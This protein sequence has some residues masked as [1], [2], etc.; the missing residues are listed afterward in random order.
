MRLRFQA[1]VLLF[2]LLPAVAIASS[3]QSLKCSDKRDGFSV[4]EIQLEGTVEAG[5][6]I[7]LPVAEDADRLYAGGKLLGSTGYLLKYPFSARF[8]PRIYSLQPLQGQSNPVLTLETQNY[9]SPSGPPFAKARV[10]PASFPLRKAYLP[11]FLRTFAFFAL[12]ALS[13]FVVSRIRR[14]TVDGWMYPAEEM[15]WFFGSICCFLLLHSSYSHILVPGLWDALFHEAATKA[16]LAVGLWCLSTL[17]LN[18]RFNDR[19]CV[20]R[21][22]SRRPVFRFHFLADFALAA[23]L[24]TIVP[25][26]RASYPVVLA[27]HSL[28]LLLSLHSSVVSLEWRRVLKRSGASPLLF[29]FSL[30]AFGGLAALFPIFHIALGLTPAFLSSLAWAALL[31]GAFRMHSYLKARRRSRELV[32]E[33]REIL[34]HHSRADARLHALCEFIE[35]EWA[36]ARVSIISVESELGLVIASAGPEAIPDVHRS[37]ARKLGPFLRRV[38]RAGHILY[39]PVAEELGQDLQKEGLKHSSLAI[40]LRQLGKV[41]AVLCM[42]ADEGERIPPVEATVLELLAA[43][44]SLE[45]LS[46]SA[47]HVA[48][49]KCVH[50]LAIARQADGIAVEHLDDWGHLHYSDKEDSRYLVGAK[51]EAMLAIPGSSA[52]KKAQGE[53]SRE[54]RAIWHALALS[55]EFVP[56]EIKEDFWVLSPKEFRNPFLR[57]LGP[58]RVSLLLAMALDRQAR[59]LA[60]KEGFLLLAQPAF[61]VVAGSARLHLVSYGAQETGAYEVDALDLD[62]LRRLRDRAPAAGPACFSLP[63]SAAGFELRAVRAGREDE[64]YFSILSLFADKKELRKIENKALETAR[65]SLRKAA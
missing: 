54:L 47:Q 63:E 61:R 27:I 56:R 60:A 13:V 29:H 1:A 7:F 44:L 12:A 64:E 34:V 26:L 24:I 40:P 18:A 50:L 55:F 37:R 8:L 51:F 58:E 52:L 31:L 11:L 35:D 32:K 42:M 38:C 22:I 36:A 3:L 20:E 45:I 4:C 6:R 43:D 2:G 48:E 59:A 23:S 53:F 25:P 10:I 30:L 57:S 28:P 33:C 49:T 21:G 17:L 62:R 65:E 19:S 39:A 15:R 41:R 9:F 14:A 16:A 5:E 46:A